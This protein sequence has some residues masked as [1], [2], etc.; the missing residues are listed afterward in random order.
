MPLRG[1][2]GGT[3]RLGDLEGRHRTARLLE[4]GENPGRRRRS[5]RARSGPADGRGIV[6]VAQLP[7]EIGLPDLLPLPIA[8]ETSVAAQKVLQHLGGEGLDDVRHRPRAQ[9]RTDHLRIRDRREHNRLDIGLADEFDP[10]A[11]GQHIVDEK[12]ID[13]VLGDDLACRLQVADGFERREAGHLVDV[14]GMD[15]PDEEIVIEHEN[16]DHHLSS[17][18]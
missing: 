10:G 1:R 13:L 18:C 2:T 8:E 6:E 16:V 14:P 11:L 5:R 3:N 12:Q 17:S 9:R 15:L 7:L 4:R